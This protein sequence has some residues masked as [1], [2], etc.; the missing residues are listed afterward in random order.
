[1]KKVQERRLRRQYR[2]VTRREEYYVARRTIGIDVQR[3][4]RRR[5]GRQK[6]RWLDSV[7]AEHKEKKLSG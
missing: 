4:R 3:K 5:G 2:H 1:M 6:R 7:R